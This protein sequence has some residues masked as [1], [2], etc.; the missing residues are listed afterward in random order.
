MGVQRGKIG[1]W[2]NQGGGRKRNNPSQLVIVAQILISS[3]TVL[4]LFILDSFCEMQKGMNAVVC[5]E[6]IEMPLLCGKRL[7]EA[8]NQETWVS[9]YERLPKAQ[10]VVKGALKLRDLWNG[11]GRESEKLDGWIAEMDVLGSTV[12]GIAMSANGAG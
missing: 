2:L 10:S 11:A 8:P 12:L 7:W 4:I 6:I 1:S 9:E 3:R 5:P